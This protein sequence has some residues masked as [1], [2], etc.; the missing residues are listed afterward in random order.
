MRRSAAIALLLPVLFL[1]GC[2]QDADTPAA[3]PGASESTTAPVEA[4]STGS[5]A[6][7][8]VL[9]AI[10]VTGDLGAAPTVTFTPEIVLTA[11]AAV[12]VSEGEGAVLEEGQSV[13]LDFAVYAGDDVASLGSSWQD[14]MPTTIV[15]GDP[16]YYPELNAVLSGQRIGARVILGL[17]GN[18][19]ATA[20]DTYPVTLMVI[21]VVDARTVPARAEGETVE[22]A[23]GL[24]L[25]TLAD[26]GEPSI[27]I[28]A[29]AV[30]PTEL[31]VQPLIKGAGATIEAGQ[32]V[33]F[34][35]SGWLW[36]GTPFDSSWAKGSPFVSPLG[37]GQLIEGWD[38]G[39]VG[40]TL[41]SQVLLVVP[42]DLGYGPNG[43]QTIPGGA[44]LIFV[45]DLLDAA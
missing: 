22:P 9:A 31:V 37:V 38:T 16:T 33:T 12:V 43:S 1:A 23:A 30:E 11:A 3:E 40:Q 26:S 36:D 45:V 4:A 41:G 13:S 5:E 20:E 34:H 42:S 24:P 28:P 17:P 19:G 21:E 29:D 15:L 35:Y 10:E 7:R 39:L 32:S 2:G 14:G 27:E 25:V 6:D 18:E 8:A 44:T